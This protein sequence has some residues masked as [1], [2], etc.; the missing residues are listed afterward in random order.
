MLVKIALRHFAKKQGRQS[1]LIDPRIVTAMNQQAKDK[2]RVEAGLPEPTTG[3][4]RLQRIFGRKNKKV[5]EEMPLMDVK[6]HR[7]N[8]TSNLDI[9]QGSMENQ[10]YGVETG[11]RMLPRKVRFKVWGALMALFSWFA[12]CFFLIAY[13]L[14]SD[15][16]ELMEREVYEELKTKK[17]VERFMVKNKKDDQ[18]QKQKRLNEDYSKEL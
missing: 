1:P 14:R 15:D 5:S 8:Y 13:R 9:S 18:F 17:E 3:T 4:S 6:G 2:A 7:I 12:A 11:P 10:L 16:L